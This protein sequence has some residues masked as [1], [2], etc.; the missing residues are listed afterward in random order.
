MLDHK[1]STISFVFS[2]I[3][4]PQSHKAHN[5]VFYL[6]GC[7]VF[8]MKTKNYKENL[9]IYII[10]IQTYIVDIVRNK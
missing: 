5:S 7:F 8:F 9:L 6:F 1:N 2:E 3:Y 10:Q 4:I